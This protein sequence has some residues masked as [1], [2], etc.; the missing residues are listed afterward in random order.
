MILKSNYVPFQ[1][2]LE[3]YGSLEKYGSS[4]ENGSLEE[5]ED[6]VEVEDLVELKGLA[7]YE[8]SG[9]SIV[10]CLTEYIPPK[11]PT[12][13]LAI[14]HHDDWK[15]LMEEDDEL[16]IMQTGNVFDDHI[17]K[18]EGQPCG[19]EVPDDI[20]IGNEDGDTLRSNKNASEGSNEANSE[21]ND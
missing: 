3:E 1:L 17:F 12:A 10:R 15:G 7:A 13:S 5:D 8:G 19:L 9:K 11:A 14:A 20:T 16:L 4:E 6:L 18:V 2:D 21:D